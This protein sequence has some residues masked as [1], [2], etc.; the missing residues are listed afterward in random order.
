[1]AL[2]PLKFPPGLFK[3]ATSYAG[4]G[5]WVDGNLV[6]YREGSVRPVGGWAT[7]QA[8]GV[9]IASVIADAS[10]EAVRDVFAWRDNDQTQNFVLGSNLALYYMTAG[11]TVTDVAHADYDA[12]N[13][14]KDAVI[15]FGY[16]YGPYG[17]SPY[18][19]AVNSEGQD[20]QPP[21]RWYFANFGEILLTGARN[22]GA[23]YEL[24]TSAPDL[25]AV[26]NAPTDLQDIL[27]TEQRQVFAIGGGGQSRRVQT[28]DAEDRTDWTPSI[29]NQSIDRTL[30]GT[31]RLLSVVNILKQVLIL[32][33][34]DVHAARYIGPP[35]VYSIE[36]IGEQCGPL[37]AQAISSTDRLAFWWGDR[38]F[39]MYDGTVQTIACD[40][41]D[42]LYKDLSEPQISKISSFTN[43]AFSEIW[44]L[45]QSLSSAT[46]EVD[47]YV[48][49]NY[50][51]LAWQTGR[52]D[53][54]AGVDQ[55]VLANV[56]MTS[57]AGLVINHELADVLPTEGDIFIRSGP[58]DIAEGAANIAI[59]DVFP[60]TDGVGGL[61]I[62]FIGKAMPDEPEFT[63][64]PYAYANPINTRAFGR[65][66]SLRV[67]FTG[68][69]AEWGN[70]R[71]DVK[72]MGT[73][74]R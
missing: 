47:S 3:N 11:G 45:Y 5:R 8:L 44:W 28:S 10:L 7:R 34:N 27:V 70:C 56:T 68:A 32:G 22:N 24:D 37:C 64:G 20:A 35:Y 30:S 71:I 58:I 29:S 25:T 49:Y 72:D 55:G 63:Y 9:D 73:G 52:I 18:G 43:T 48:V 69:S 40:V 59:G 39:W 66:L 14:S 16:G 31:G 61:S 60:D 6:R 26:A 13:S 46:G 1:M 12:N 21:D 19:V 57:S 42:F 54:T 50:V 23:L 15:P 2:A 38:K 51:T 65:E 67:D 53:R 17:T 41:I 36:Q 62:S 74:T 4:R 33:E